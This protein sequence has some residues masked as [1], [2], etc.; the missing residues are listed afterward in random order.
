[1][2]T[3]QRARG[4]ATT[5]SAFTAD[6]MRTLTLRTIALMVGWFSFAGAGVAAVPVI[7]NAYAFPSVVGVGDSVS[8]TLTAS[9]HPTSFGAAGLPTGL[10]IDSG[11]GT[12]SGS[13][14]VTGTF[15]IA[16][17]ATNADGSDTRNVTTRVDR[18]DRPPVVL[19]PAQ[20][21]SSYYLYDYPEY[22][23]F[24][25]GATNFPDSFDLLDG[26]KRISIY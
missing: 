15:T 24:A 18:R 25:I 2:H 19:G 20:F 23:H 8:F 10:A 22:P 21:E 11:T 1:V 4:G 7:S 13:P 12:I 6:L 5:V 14:Q 26:P 3:Y 9:N 16:L 17:S